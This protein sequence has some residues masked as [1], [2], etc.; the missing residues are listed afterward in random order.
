MQSLK[1]SQTITVKDLINVKAEPYSSPVFAK[2]NSNLRP[3]TNDPKNIATASIKVSH[4]AFLKGQKVHL[5]IDLYH[6]SKI[7]R[8]PGCFI[9]LI[10]KE[11]YYAG[12]YVG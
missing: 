1:A 12:E 9:Q 4:S 2:G 8:N 11:C 5:E 7:Q 10:R 6:P 3:D